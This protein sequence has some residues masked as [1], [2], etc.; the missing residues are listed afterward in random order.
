MDHLIFS[1]NATLPIFLTMVVGY[2]LKQFHM[3]DEHF[4]KILNKF[5]FN[6]T[7]PAL[8]F[9]DLYKSDFRKVWD[10]KYV[11]F[12]FL[13]TVFCAVAIS[14]LTYFFLKDKTI[15]GEFIQGCYRSSSAVLGIAFIMN[16]YGE[17][18]TTPLMIIGTV[19]FY[20]AFAVLILSFTDPQKIGTGNKADL[21]QFKKSLKGIATNPII[22]GILAGMLFSI[23]KIPLPQIIIKTTNNLGCLATPLALIALGASFEGR[24]ALAKIKPTIICTAVKLLIL[25]AIFLPIAIQMGFQ[26]EKLVGILIMLGAPTTVSSFIMA[27]NMN[28]EGVLTSSVIV[29]TTFL[30]SVS[31]TFF[32]F[33]L[34]NYGLI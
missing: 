8:V 6:I 30:S 20:N 13:V 29:S 4:V 21:T 14:I 23:C 10:T 26:D 19:P 17:V 27:K 11:L 15:L 7:L 3:L 18:H 34:K 5:N 32:L 33:L 9:L 25:P 16:I 12:C 22:L 1:L 28:H 31:I 2:V 24:K